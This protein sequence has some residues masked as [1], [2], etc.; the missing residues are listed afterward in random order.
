MA[1]VT[2]MV[3]A[4]GADRTDRRPRRLLRPLR[5]IP[6][7]RPACSIVR[8]RVA[9]VRLLAGI[10]CV[11]LAAP[12]LAENWRF[13]SSAGVTETYTSNVNYSVGGST[14]EAISPRS[15]TGALQISGDGRSRP[16]QRLDRRDGTVL[17]EGDPEQQLRADRRS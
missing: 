10:G 3:M 13:T 7:R 14:P 6:V 2:A 9:G 1:M 15:V 12:A 16:P 4:M 5:R 8:A 17:R 11:A